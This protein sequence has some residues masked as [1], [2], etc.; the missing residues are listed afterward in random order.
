M[1]LIHNIIDKYIPHLAFTVFT[2]SFILFLY[3]L[4]IDCKNV[5]SQERDTIDKIWIA[6]FLILIF[7]CVVGAAV[8]A[9][10]F[11]KKKIV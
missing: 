7:I 3:I 10:R 9:Y 2:T 11:N 5:E 8:I 4:Y 1:T 6:I